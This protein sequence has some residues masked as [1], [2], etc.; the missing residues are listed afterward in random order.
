[1]GN[2]WQEF[3]NLLSQALVYLYGIF[4]S[5]GTAIIVFTVIVRLLFLPLSVRGTKS[6]REMQTNQ[7][8]MK[9]QLEALKK[10][11]GNDRSKLM[12]E[13]QKLYKEM[14]I[15]PMAGMGGCLPMLIQ[16]PIWIALYSALYH[17]AGTPEFKASFLWIPDLSGHEQFPYLLAILTGATTWATQRMS[18]Q[19]TTDQQQKTMNNMMQFM[20]LM[21][22]FFAFQ[23]PTGLVLYWVTSNIFQFF[24]QTLHDRLG[25]ALAIARASDSGP[26]GGAGRNGC[27][28]QQRSRQAREG[29]QGGE[30]GRA[31]AAPRARPQGGACRQQQQR[32]RARCPGHGYRPV[33]RQERLA[34]VHA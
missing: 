19:P 25:S 21:M 23:V 15:N 26:A 12:E 31:P 27:R 14:G 33:H 13:Q 10:K 30:E 11:Y 20:P 6:M 16:L 7:A 8:R 17:L 34:R 5:Y 29:R 22:V 4:G 28:R 2:L 9:P 32:I 24:Q 3:I 1:M 18:V